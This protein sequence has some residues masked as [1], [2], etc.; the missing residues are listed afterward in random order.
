MIYFLQEMDDEDYSKQRKTRSCVRVLLVRGT[1]AGTLI[2]VK[3]WSVLEA[4][5]LT[6]RSHVWKDNV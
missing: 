4:R 6:N 5:F 2:V 3:R 1:T